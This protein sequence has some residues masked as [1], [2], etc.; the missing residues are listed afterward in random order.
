[1]ITKI[2][3]KNFRRFKEYTE[4]ELGDINMFVGGNNAGK[5]T[6]VKALLLVVNFLKN[7]TVFSEGLFGKYVFPL[8]APCVNI[9]T[10]SRALCWNSDEGTIS[11]HLE[12]HPFILD[13]EIFNASTQ[14]DISVADIKAITLVHKESDVIFNFNVAQ[15]TT[16]VHFGALCGDE[17]FCEIKARKD[18]INYIA[19]ELDNLETKMEES[20]LSGELNPEILKRITELKEQKDKNTKEIKDLEAKGGSEVTITI[21]LSQSLYSRNL[22]YI[23]SFIL[24]IHEFARNSGIDETKETVATRKKLKKYLDVLRTVAE[25]FNNAINS[26]NIEYL[27]AHDASQKVLFNKRDQNDYVSQ[28]VHE[29][30]D[31]KI[32]SQSEFGKMFKQWLHDF[33]IADDFIVAGTVSSIKEDDKEYFIGEGEGYAFGLNVN[34]QWHN[35]GDMG[36]GSIQLVVLFIRIII[37]LKKYNGAT[38][39]PIVLIEE[40]E[41][42]LHPAVQS[43]L[44]DLF[45][46][47]KGK[48]CIITET[49]SEYLIRKLQVVVAQALNQEKES[50]TL[51]GINNSLKVYYFPEQGLPYSMDFLQN[52]RFL[53]K[54]DTG[55]YDQSG[56]MNIDLIK[57][58]K[59]GR[60]I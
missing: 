29:F 31:A 24:G 54:F 23:T 60:G 41:Q 1:M 36:R 22:S 4:V 2:G 30:V 8:N 9:D 21:P 44:A 52:G 50:H 32:T 38:V 45:C 34:G 17:V 14:K 59:G 13:I 42:N 47:L 18:Y 11:F 58:G 55:F 19:M 16:M 12:F 6:V 33:N 28:S 40:P 57:A 10:F 5:S 39:K 48:L 46:E 27:Q 26:I 51:E 56:S 53:N 20:I 35:L 15:S 37:L 3:F 7:S 43:K 49:H 25:D